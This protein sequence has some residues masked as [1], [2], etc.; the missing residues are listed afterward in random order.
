MT[1]ATK[2]SLFDLIS[3]FDGIQ[4][5]R[6]FIDARKVGEEP[7]AC[8]IGG[9]MLASGCIDIIDGIKGTEHV[10][11]KGKYVWVENPRTKRTRRVVFRNP[12]TGEAENSPAASR[13]SDV[14]S[15]AQ[16]WLQ[17]HWDIKA[18]LDKQ[19]VRDLF[20]VEDLAKAIISDGA[21]STKTPKK[22]DLQH[23][24]EAVNPKMSLGAARTG[25]RLLAAS[26][27]RTDFNACIYNLND[28]MRCTPAQVVTVLEK[29]YSRVDLVPICSL[30][31]KC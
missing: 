22:E 8:A 23:F 28:T 16:Q 26:A 31:G 13:I 11:E 4:V 15:A 19:G 12:Q 2:K 9:G 1:K 20:T 7:M 6:H 29:L 3:E 10:R 18:T 17:K 27:Q 14:D 24:R 30:D 21:L 25:V 5:F